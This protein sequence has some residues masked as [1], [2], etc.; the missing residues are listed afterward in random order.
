MRSRSASRYLELNAGETLHI[1]LDPGLSSAGG[2]GFVGYTTIGVSGTPRYVLVGYST[3]DVSG[4][5]R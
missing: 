5:P 4:T 2:E 3:I 1:K